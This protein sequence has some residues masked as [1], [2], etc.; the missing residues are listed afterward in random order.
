MG[1]TERFNAKAV[2]VTESGCW[3]WTG[4]LSCKGYGIMKISGKQCR[5]HRVSWGLHRGDIPDGQYVLHRCDTPACVNP[6]HLFLG[7]VADNN[8]DMT[9]KGRQAR[10][11][12]E[13]NGRAKLTLAQV[14]DIVKDRRLLR[15]IAKDYGVHSTTIS[16]I[17]LG[18]R[19]KTQ[20]SGIALTS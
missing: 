7:T 17:R 6:D 8:A 13:A 20:P 19:W 18:K 16:M 12:G 5:A 15:E 9:T 14:S 10:Q 1:L 4:E 11:P 3:L 2:P